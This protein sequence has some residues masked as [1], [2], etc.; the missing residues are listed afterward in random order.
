MDSEKLLSVPI[1][2]P[3]R[4]REFRQTSETTLTLV[5][6]ATDSMTMSTQPLTE[7]FEKAF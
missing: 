2:D 3:E 5:D 7:V 1:E 6:V 4:H